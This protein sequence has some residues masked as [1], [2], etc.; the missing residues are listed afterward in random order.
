[1]FE[2]GVGRSLDGLV[3]LARRWKPFDV[4]GDGDGVGGGL[5]GQLAVRV[6]RTRMRVVSM[7][8]RVFW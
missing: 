2:T 6:A 8:A 7:L 5:V 4:D 1:M 3:S